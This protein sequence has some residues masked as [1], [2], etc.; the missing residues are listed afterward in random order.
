MLIYGLTGSIAMGKSTAARMLRHFGLPVYDSDYVVHEFYKSDAVELLRP[1][2]PDAIISGTVDRVSLSNYVLNSPENLRKLESIVHPYVEKQREDF[3]AFKKLSGSKIVFV[4]IPLL[5][6][7]G[8]ERMVDRIVVVSASEETQ[9][10]RAL[11]RANMT[12]AKFEA[13]KSK[14]IPDTDKRRMAHYI[15]SSDHGFDHMRSQIKSL[16]RS[17]N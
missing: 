8:D 10:S 7:I 9:R 13:I 6:E 12:I 16:L 14:Q 3:L 15:I 4:D 1:Y 2:F 17:V 5:F 11:A